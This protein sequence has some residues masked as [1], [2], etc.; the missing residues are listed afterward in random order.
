MK[1]RRSRTVAVI[2]AVLI[3]GGALAL[4]HWCRA[5]LAPVA[6]SGQSQ[7]VRIERGAGASRIARQLEAANLIRSAPALELYLAYSGLGRKLKAGAFE[8]APTMS[9]VEMVERIAAGQ[10]GSRK[11]TVP[12]GLRLEEIAE[13]VADTGLATADEFI[14]AATP[15]TMAGQ[16]EFDLPKSSLEG[17]LLPETYEF[18]LDTDA[19]QIVLRMVRELEREFVTPNAEAIA[20][21]KLNLHEIITLA[22]LVERE[23]RVAEERATIAGVLTNRLDIGMKLQC[24][25]TVQY[26]LDEHKPRLTFNDLKVESPYNTYL[27]KGLPPGPIAAPGL[28]CLEAALHPART[29]AL[30]YVA[31]PDGRHVFARTYEEH[32]AAIR[33]I[34]GE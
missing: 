4:G 15:E 22:S 20:A 10:T 25:A 32:L 14:A 33:T 6:T 26:A 29:D 17:Y 28:A 7:I 2:L 21:S 16:V 31:R 34:R 27:H 24:D 8:L 18:A 3:V 19:R 9:G 23:A 5:Q 11:I 1:N 12:E 30:F 13:R